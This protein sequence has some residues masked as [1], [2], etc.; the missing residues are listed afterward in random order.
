MAR[1]AAI[2]EAMRRT[3]DFDQFMQLNEQAKEVMK[4]AD[5]CRA[6]C[7]QQHYMKYSSEGYVTDGMSLQ[8]GYR[9]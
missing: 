9:H 6:A 3:E 4:A 2:I 1:H 5:S 8:R 7:N